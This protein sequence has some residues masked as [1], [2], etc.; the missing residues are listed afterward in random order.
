MEANSE[1][2]LRII[3][4]IN[5]FSP[6]IL[7]VG[8]GMPR[9]ERW[10]LNNFKQVSANAVLSSG[11]CFDYIAGEQKTPP[12]F[13]GKIGLEWFYRLINDPKRLSR[14]YFV[15]PILLIPVVFKDIRSRYFL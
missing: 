1:E 4:K 11:A 3:K 9:Q 12:R 10:I 2:N 8:M 15:E 14:R 13:L 6:N 5:Q 7:M